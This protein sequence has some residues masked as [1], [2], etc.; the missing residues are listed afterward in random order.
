[1]DIVLCDDW[2]HFCP[3]EM[4]ENMVWYVIPC[5]Y[6]MVYAS[7]MRYMNDKY[8]SQYLYALLAPVTH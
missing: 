2:M 5:R 8:T 3:S 1:M 4:V 7:V 6:M